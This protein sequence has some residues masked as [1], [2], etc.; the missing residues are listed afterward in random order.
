MLNKKYLL[1]S[2]FISGLLLSACSTQQSGH[3]QLLTD[4][5]AK[6]I[7]QLVKEAVDSHIAPG[8]V[9][10]MYQNNQLVFSDTYGFRSIEQNTALQS[11]D[12]FRI[13]SMTKPVTAVAALIL[14]EQGKLT[15]KDEVSRYIP[16]FANIRVFSS[17]KDR[18]S[19]ETVSLQRP[20][21]V[22]DLMTHTAGFT[23]GL[24][25]GNA[26]MEDYLYKGIP[27]GSGADK[28][29][30]DGS[31]AVASLEEFSQRIAQV[32]LMHQ[33]GSNWT[34]GNS[35]DVLGRVVE[36]ASGMRLATFMQEEIFKP[37]GMTETS[38]KITEAQKERFTDAYLSKGQKPVPEGIFLTREQYWPVN[39]TLVTADSGQKSIYSTERGIDFGGAGLVSTIGDYAKFSLMLVNGGSFNGHTI[40]SPASIASM[41]SNHLSPQAMA[42]SNYGENGM[43]FGLTVASID[44]NSKLPVCVPNGGYFWG[45]AASTFFFIDPVNNVTVLMFTQVF[46]NQVRPVWGE[47]LKDVYGEPQQGAIEASC[48]N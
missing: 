19:M 1:S 44:D 41:S 18:Q 15:L 12:L 17:G 40:L 6:Q 2:L 24:Y 31:K 48:G 39:T 27:T 26:V 5:Q 10:Q 9:T 30:L 16:E 28:P 34:Y 7:R 35:I 11:D 38:F 25:P 32:P 14:I 20:I 46:G 4:R 33:P 8:F 13:Y 3:K 43:T 29:P 42:A 37:L 21:T 45:G 22:E 36:V 47:L 23:Y